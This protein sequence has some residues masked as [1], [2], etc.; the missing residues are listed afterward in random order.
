MKLL[1]IESPGKQKTIQKYLGADWR[2]VASFG[3]IRGLE[4]SLDFLNTDFEPK[5]EFLK[6]KAKAIKELKE[7]AK[8]ASAGEIYLGADKDT[9][10]EGIAYSV[11]LLLKLNPK[12]AKRVTFTEITEKAIQHAIQHPDTID[13]DRVNTQKAR[14]VLDMLIGFTMSPLLWRYVAPSLSA[15]RCQTP[16]LRLVVEREQQIADFQVTSSWQLTGTWVSANGGPK[17]FPA[18]MDDELEDKESVLNYLENIHTTPEGTVQSK[19]IRPWTERAPEA[20]MTSTL[21]QQASALYH[22]NPKSTMQIAQKLYE[23]GHITYM[24]T[25]QAT[26]SQDAVISARAWVTQHYGEAFLGDVRESTEES[27]PKKKVKK[28]KEDGAGAEGGPKAQEAHEAI[29]PTHMEYTELEG[30]DW[31]N[32]DRKVYRLIWQRAI[33]SVMAAAKGEHVKVKLHIKDDEFLWTAQWKRT[34]FEGWKQAGKVASIDDA[35]E[36]DAVDT[37]DAEEDAW[38]QMLTLQPGDPVRWQTIQAEPKETRAQGR[39]TEATLVRALETFGIGRPSTFASLLATIQDKGYVETRDI[40]PREV[41]VTEYRLQPAVWP[42][43]ERAYQ[44]K[45]GAEKAKLVPTD[46]G[47]SVLHFILQHFQDLF[48]YGFTAQMERRLDRIAE[49]Q[50][51]W[52]QVLK[53]TWESYRARYENLLSKQSLQPK[54]GQP[55]AK[56]REFTGGLKAVQSKKGPLLLTEGPTKEDTQFFGWPMGIAFPDMTEELARAFIQEEQTR[57]QGAKIGEWKG[58]EIRKK[59]GKFGDYLQCGDTNIPFL[60]NE[61]L[62]KTVERLE[63]KAT[64]GSAG[65]GA[66]AT[67]KEFVI[68]TGPYGPYIMK[69]SLKKA[70]FVSLPKGLDPVKLTEKEVDALYK[71]GL[72][73]KKKYQKWKG[74]KK[75]A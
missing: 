57:R 24:R 26:M 31:T 55:S 67:F 45:V 41:H 21:Q 62:E 19:D 3:H 28:A 18:R 50:E 1:I 36:E 23:A 63:A 9:E 46:L 49:G 30:A 33:Q 51:P 2:V 73:E 56:V 71:T 6:E 66:V 43:Q 4:Q 32:T 37:V 8:H 64:G 65:A 52:K 40:P 72:E 61:S 74:A 53:D 11:C 34:T 60:N 27:K 14:A 25:D 12:T 22:L 15:G 5:Y 29:R 20:L 35:S 7:Q 75:T 48:D 54:E 47:R 42:P 70:Q 44:K 13:M 16:A 38:Q 39:Y 69:T 58:Q 10:G 17:D 68:R 59:T